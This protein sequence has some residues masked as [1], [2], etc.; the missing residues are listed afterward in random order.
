[1]KAKKTL[2]AKRLLAIA[3]IVVALP[4]LAVAQDQV[5]RPEWDQQKAEER[6]QKI[7]ALEKTGQPWDKIAWLTDTNQAVTRAHQENKPVFVYFF[8]K[9]NVGPAAAPC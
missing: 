2:K 8:L 4:L 1:M 7:L 3:A 6:V 9:K 5:K